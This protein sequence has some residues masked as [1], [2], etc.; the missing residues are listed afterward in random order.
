MWVK[1]NIKEWGREQKKFIWTHSATLS[2]M[3]WG[4]HK[5]QDKQQRS[6]TFQARRSSF[7][8][9]MSRTSRRMKSPNLEKL[10]WKHLLNEKITLRT[11]HELKGFWCA[12]VDCVVPCTAKTGVHLLWKIQ[13]YIYTHTYIEDRIKKIQRIEQRKEYNAL[14]VFLP[15]YVPAFPFCI[16]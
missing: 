8:T 6:G 12:T 3:K 9:R 1:K 10:E 15:S 14:Q 11:R 7:L 4:Q 5:A 16:F 2:S 13:K